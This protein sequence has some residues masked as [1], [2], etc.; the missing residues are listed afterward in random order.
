MTTDILRPRIDLL[1]QE[2][3]LVQ[4]WKKTASYIRYHNWFSDTL[5][6]DRT[7]I[8]LPSFIAE[9]GERLQS[10]DQWENDPLRIVPAPKSQRWCVSPHSGAWEPKERGMTAARLRP[11]AHV[12]LKDQVVATALMLCLADRVETKQGDPRRSIRD[13]ASRKQII[14]YGNRLF[15]DTVGEELR[16]RWGSAKLYR[17]YYQDYRTFLSRAEL[18]AESIMLADGQRVIIVYSDLRQFYDRVRPNRLAAALRSIQH[19]EDDQPFFELAERVLDWG[20]HFRDER[21]VAIYA[22]QAELQDFARVALPQGLVSAGFFANIA[23]LEFDDRLRRSFTTEIATDVQLKDACRYVDDLRVVVT[24][25]G[26]KVL[27]QVANEVSDWL[28]NLLQEAV[29]GLELSKEKTKA[30]EFGGGEHPLVRQSA[31]MNRIQSAV[32]GGFDAIGGEEILDSIQGLIRSQ[33]ALSQETDDSG[34]RFSPL[35]DVRDETVARFAAGRFRTT[36]RSIRPLLEEGSAENIAVA[37]GGMGPRTGHSRPVRNQRELD[38]DARAFA[39]GLIDRWVE[40]PSNVRLLRIGL[41]LWPDVEILK[42]VLDLLKPFTERGGRRK[43]P[44]RVAW[45]C[46]SEILRAGAT[47]TGLVEDDECLPKRVNLAAYRVALRDEA[48]RLIA[49]PAPTIPWYLRQQAFLFLAAHD[50]KSAPV[51]RGGRSAETKHYRDLI[52]F[53]RGEGNQLKSSDFATLAVLSRR[54][55]LDKERAAQLT[56]QGLTPARQREIAERDPSFARELIDA[57]VLLFDGLPARLREDLCLD[58]TANSEDF[59]TLAEIVVKDGPTGPFRNE[60]ALLRF[61][62]AFLR[63]FQ[64][65]TNEIEVIAPGQVRL[66]LKLRAKS[67]IADTKELEVVP[68]RAAPAGSLYLPPAWCAQNERW[69]FQLGYLLRFI[70]AGRPDFTR[71]VRSSHWKE[72]AAV[73]RAAE[74][75]WYQRLYGLF[76][77]Q[78]AFGDDWLPITDWMEQLL[79]ALLRWPGCR[80]PEGF[81]CVMRGIEATMGKVQGRIAELERKCGAATGILIMPLIAAR[82]TKQQGLRPLRACIVQTAIPA[83]EHFNEKDLTLISTLIRKRHRNHLSASLAAVE[84][85]LAL[86]E[87][88]NESEGRL[89]WLIL[90]ELAVHPLDVATHLIPFARAHRT[91]VLAGMTYQ[92]IFP[93]QPLVNSALW[94]IPEWTDSYGLQVRIRRQGKFHLAPNEESFNNGGSMRLQGFR[95]CQWLVGYRWSNDLSMRPVWLTASVC[96]DATDLGLAADLRHESDILAI[97]ALNKDVRTFDQMALALHYHMFQLVV[98]ANNGQYGGSNAYWPSSD[99]HKRQIFHLHGQPQASIAFLEIEDIAAFLERRN[100]PGSGAPVWKYPPAGM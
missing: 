84:R 41:D 94:I 49:L 87:T 33:Q 77:G 14:S 1:R 26:A 25:E 82:P 42:A 65:D 11:L 71:S 2:Y 13:A 85:M 92:E 7:A 79:S 55:F 96:Y 32:S 54:A 86:R 75:H 100:N 38:E 93:G 23:L 74:S 20:W 89:D 64:Q 16:H 68:S 76:N 99:I 78:P 43:A 34:W 18:V 58:T 22:E 47:E 24:V 36:Y 56:S 66:K 57:S 80:E 15:C 30:A 90:P 61:A 27:R 50:P 91:I 63:W 40:D 17:E 9:V 60:L 70:L 83:A 98:V 8:N 48:A 37:N 72:G 44:R 45:Y 6:L 4:A 95:P 10:P 19:D 31:K 69:R 52:R 39:L 29:P 67:G 53:L 51:F 21:E 81:D 59:R 5:E 12:S 28:Q 88:H 73:Y 46:L 62:A 97:P 3:V 35:P